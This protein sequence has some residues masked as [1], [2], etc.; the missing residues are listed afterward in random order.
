[1]TVIACGQRQTSIQNGP[2]VSGGTVSLMMA[3][4]TAPAD[5]Y[6]GSFVTLMVSDVGGITSLAGVASDVGTTWNQRVNYYDP[7]TTLFIG[8]WDAVAAGGV[9]G[10]TLTVTYSGTASGSDEW[11]AQESV[12]ILQYVTSNIAHGTGAAPLP[13]SLSPGVP[14]AMFVTAAVSAAGMSSAPSAPGWF[15]SVSDNSAFAWYVANGGDSSA[16]TSAYTA[17]GSAAWAALL[18]VY[19]PI[20]VGQAIP[21][22]RQSVLL[23][24][25]PDYSAGPVFTPTLPVDPLPGSLLVLTYSNTDTASTLI[26]TMGS[27]SSPGAS[28]SQRI[29]LTFPL[30]GAK[31]CE[32]AAVFE[33]P[34]VAGTSGGAVVTATCAGA[35]GLPANAGIMVFEVQNAKAIPYDKSSISS[36]T[37]SNP[38][39]INIPTLNP[40]GGGEICVELAACHHSG[41][42][43]TNPSWA[44]FAAGDGQVT[45]IRIASTSDSSAPSGYTLTSNAGS[46]NNSY[47]TGAVLY[48]PIG[49]VAPPAGNPVD[50]IV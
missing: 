3:L 44:L 9:G 14:N 25:G 26:C 43:P 1:V 33:A 11:Q 20:T 27:V 31:Y 13:P 34:G 23:S 19:A 40:A 7:V 21:V 39:Q 47:V 38:W 48:K 2:G 46:G 8:L 36:G 29:Q 41:T 35:T 28:W 45:G 49:P 22:L 5:P 18:A 37:A 42:T 10:G 4:Q 50:M 24:T 32:T 17:T 30:T 15:G 16:H 6:A 12:N